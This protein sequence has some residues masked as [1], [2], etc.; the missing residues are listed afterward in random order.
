[1]KNW[2]CL[3]LVVLDQHVD[4]NPDWVPTQKV[5]YETSDQPELENIIPR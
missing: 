4:L 2:P 5:G 1:M 3:Q